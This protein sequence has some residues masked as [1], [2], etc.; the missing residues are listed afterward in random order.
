MRTILALP[1]TFL[2]LLPH[3]RPAAESPAQGSE[4]ME[5]AMA[6]VAAIVQPG[7]SHELLGRF[8]G[9]WKAELGMSMG[10]PAT[11]TSGS[12]EFTWLMEG[13][14]LQSSWSTSMMGM[15]LIS[16]AWLGYDNFKQSFVT[17]QVSSMDT[18]M[19]RL[20]GDLDPGGKTLILYGTLDEYLTGEHDKM[21]KNVWRF[22]SE[23]EMILEVHDLPIG[24]QNTK[25]FE[26]RMT[27]E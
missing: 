25:V 4:Q 7:P 27:R 12:I 19:I 24:E 2:F 22:L 18:A 3:W 10:G 26:V 5:A 9:K 1:A 15:P 8:L 16:H 6:K 23:K 11:T 20:E 17:T 21:I 14:W 13:R